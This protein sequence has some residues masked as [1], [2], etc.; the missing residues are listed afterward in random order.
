MEFKN[1][2]KI[3]GPGGKEVSKI[4]RTSDGVILW[5]PNGTTIIDSNGKWATNSIIYQTENAGIKES[6]Y[7]T[8]YKQGQPQ[9]TTYKNYR[10]FMVNHDAANLVDWLIPIPLNYVGKTLHIDKVCTYLATT[11]SGFTPF[12][13]LGWALYNSTTKKYEPYNLDT[14]TPWNYVASGGY[15]TE[16]G[17]VDIVLTPSVK[18]PSNAAALCLY[19]SNVSTGRNDSA[20]AFN[21]MYIK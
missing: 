5:Q 15:W 3:I 7:E 20:T 16:Q 2:T 18:K 10:V 13:G 9:T 19:I 11:L 14:I 21:N 1:I 8:Y 6:E 4:T 17:S 12:V